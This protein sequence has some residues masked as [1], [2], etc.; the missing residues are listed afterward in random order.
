MN[1]SLRQ[2]LEGGLLNTLPTF[3]FFLPF[4]YCRVWEVKDFHAQPVEATFQR[5]GHKQMFAKDF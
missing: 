5:V 3:I 2:I 1:Y 4:L